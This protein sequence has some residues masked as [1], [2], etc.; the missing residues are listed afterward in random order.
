VD[1]WRLED[2]QVMPD[3]SAIA[4]H[5]IIGVE[6]QPADD[7]HVSLELYRKRWTEVRPYYE[8][9][10][11]SLSLVP[12]LAPDRI[13]VAPMASEAAGAE[14]TVR[15]SLPRSF[16]V[17]GGFSAS[18][19]ADDF[20]SMKDVRRSWDQPRAM[21]LGVGWNNLGWSASAVFGWHRGW[22][23]TDVRTSLL[24]PGALIIGR[25]NA[26]R[27]GD[28]FS[29]DLSASHTGAFAGGELS[30]WL[31]LTNA[32]NRRNACCAHLLA[33][34]AGSTTLGAEPNNWLPRMVN[35]GF[36]WRFRKTP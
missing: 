13:R 28:Y 29:A 27:W 26:D 19:V 14:L 2:P 35:V 30:T 9:I 21:T 25:R 31:E 33:P 10:F 24:Q 5:S 15:R 36:T 7:V 1:E 34:D 4:I 17:W 3:P 23:R 22:P 8:N 32:T 12:D 16:E 11:D 6:Y 20:A 18:R